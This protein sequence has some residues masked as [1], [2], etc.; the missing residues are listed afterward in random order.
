MRFLLAFVALVGLVVSTLALRV[1]YSNDLQPCD[2]NEKWDCGIVNHSPYSVLGGVPLL[3]KVPGLKDVPVAVVGM[4]GYLVL[5]G[6]ALMR[7]RGAVLLGCLIGLGFSLYLT[8]IE[9]DVLETWCIYCVASL[10]LIS[11]ETLLAAGW[12]IAGRRRA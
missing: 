9:K 5:L 6:L 10:G 3:G 4:A 8:H 7:R 1:H 11:L 2:I 12:W